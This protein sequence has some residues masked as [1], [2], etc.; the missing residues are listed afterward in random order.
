MAGFEKEPSNSLPMK[1]SV[2]ALLDQDSPHHNSVFPFQ[3]VSLAHVTEQ[4]F[5]QE[6]RS[7]MAHQ[8]FLLVKTPKC[9]IEQL[10]KGLVFGLGM[11][12]V[13]VY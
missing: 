12:L 9:S 1:A 3:M 10:V 8:A 13:A 11:G 4:S 7:F 2:K 6:K 5:S